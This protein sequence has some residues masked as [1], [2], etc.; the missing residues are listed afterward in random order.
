MNGRWR[1]GLT[2]C[3]RETMVRKLYGAREEIEG[4]GA[5]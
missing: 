4:T 1:K 5:H 2:G 3:E